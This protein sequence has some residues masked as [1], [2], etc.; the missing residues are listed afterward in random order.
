[1]AA[2]GRCHALRNVDGGPQ[3][4]SAS[5]P[6]LVVPCCH[7]CSNYHYNHHH[8]SSLESYQRRVDT[9]NESPHPLLTKYRHVPALHRGTSK[10]PVALPHPLTHS[11]ALCPGGGCCFCC[12]YSPVLRASTSKR[13][14]VSS[15]FLPPLAPNLTP[16]LCPW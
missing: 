12:V 8:P 4:P 5:A 15:P 13:L 1:M 14:A 6:I 10:A 7:F 3:N 16:T 9:L 11:Q 2:P